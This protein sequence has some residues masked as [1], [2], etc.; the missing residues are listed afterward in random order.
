MHTTV[1]EIQAMLVEH[2][3]E[4]IGV[5]YEHRQPVGV[6]FQLPTAQGVRSFAMPVNV[7]GVA[8]LLARQSKAGQLKK[9]APR[10][11]WATPEQAARVAWRVVKDWLAAQLALIEAEMATMGQVMLP[12]MITGPDGQTLYEQYQTRQLGTS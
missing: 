10:G 11:G 3:A 8:A 6:H 5:R 2:G 4:A 9:A 1:G 7:E 12:Y